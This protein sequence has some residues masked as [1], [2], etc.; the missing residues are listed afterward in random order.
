MRTFTKL[1]KTELKLNIRNMNMVI[2]AIFMP[3]VVLVILGFI[4]QAKPVKYLYIRVKPMA[5]GTKSKGTIRLRIYTKK[6]PKNQ[7]IL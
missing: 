4:Y 2:F 5:P 1:L 7:L 3:I 6:H